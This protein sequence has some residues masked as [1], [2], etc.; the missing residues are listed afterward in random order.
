[1]IKF[2]TIVLISLTALGASARTNKDPHE[3]FKE[4]VKSLFNKPVF[5]S[6]SIKELPSHEFNKSEYKNQKTKLQKENYISNFLKVRD[7]NLIET[8]SGI[9]IVRSGDSTKKHTPVFKN[10]IPDGVREQMITVIKELPDK[11]VKNNPNFDRTLR[12]LYGKDGDLRLSEDGK[13]IVITDWLSN[14]K[15]ILSIIDNF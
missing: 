10:K 5:T 15:K 3:S 4:N 6:L 1:M 13:S 9:L 14:L 11:L 12:S 8:D 7:I 2:L